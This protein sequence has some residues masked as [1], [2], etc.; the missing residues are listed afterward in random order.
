MTAQE[1]TTNIILITSIKIKRVKIFVLLL[2]DVRE[3]IY[4]LKHVKD[5]LI[6]FWIQ[7]IRAFEIVYHRSSFFAYP[8]TLFGICIDNAHNS[9]VRPTGNT[10]N[11][12]GLIF[13]S[14]TSERSVLSIYK[15]LLSI[16]CALVALMGHQCNIILARFNLSAESLL[17]HSDRGNG[18][19]SF[20]LRCVT[21]KFG[22]WTSWVCWV[23][24]FMFSLLQMC[25]YHQQEN[26]RVS[27]QQE[28]A[29]LTTGSGQLLEA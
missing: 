14:L 6:Y 9:I 5:D 3:T 17:D 8:L 2:D 28:R 19:K 15:S 21:N 4:L 10:Y 1:G 7:T 16:S 12:F 22:A 25:K 26:I 20:Y 11:H 23:G 13:Y 24:L 29:R 18:A 27:M